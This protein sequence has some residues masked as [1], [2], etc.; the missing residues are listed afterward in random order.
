MRVS[1][2]DFIRELG[3]PVAATDDRLYS[4]LMLQPRIIGVVTLLGVALQS[5]ALFSVLALVLFWSALVPTGNPFDA[6][7]NVVVARRR[8]LERVAP[9]PAPR[10]FAMTMA[11]TV[12]FAIGVGLLANIRVVAWPFEALLVVAV[13]GVVFAN[14]CAGATLY[15]AVRRRLS[16][17]RRAVA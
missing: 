4:A 5:G 12:A 1:R 3:Y 14:R 17:L 8:G 9:A 6:I 7:Y 15:H 16:T 13:A 10:R 2:V 11:A